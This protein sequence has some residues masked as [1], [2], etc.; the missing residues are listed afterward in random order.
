MTATPEWMVSLHGGHNS[1]ACDH[2]SDPLEAIVEAAVARGYR[3]FGVAEHAPRVEPDRIFEEEAELGWDVAALDRLYAEHAVR[4]ERLCAE[5]ADRIT[6][7]KGME[8][9]TV[10]LGR[11][12]EVMREFRE[13]FGIEYLV[14]SVHFVDGIIIDYR[15]EMYEEASETAGGL[16]ALAVRYYEQMAEMAAALRPEVIGHFDLLRKWVDDEAALSTPRIRR[17]AFAALEVIRDTGG[18]LDVNTAGYRRGFGRPYPAPWVVEA[19]RGLGI[20]FCF[21]DD[22]HSVAQVG[23]GIVEARD[24]LLGLG[25]DS[26]TALDREDGALVRRRIPLA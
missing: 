18:I 16:E 2:A 24:Y 17:A 25:V 20:P 13:R 5:Y 12:P 3:V 14:G 15:K 10:P 22:S 8:I 6:I 9:E 7:L 21:G 4:L 19:A 26:I 1:Q 11:Y 23:A